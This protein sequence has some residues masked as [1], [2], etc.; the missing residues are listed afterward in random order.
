[1][2]S[3]GQGQEWIVNMLCALAAVLHCDPNR[4]KL[5]VLIHSGA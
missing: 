5:T 2:V 3:E 1:V 4:L